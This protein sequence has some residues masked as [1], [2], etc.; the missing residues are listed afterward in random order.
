MNEKAKVTG[1]E[2]TSELNKN[3]SQLK[4][5]NEELLRRTTELSKVNEIALGIESVKSIE[6]VYKLVVESAV[7]I[8]GV[9][10]VI[11]HQLDE[12]GE[13]ITT[14]YFSKIRTQKINT[15]LKAMGFDLEKQLGKKPTSRKLQIPIAKLKIAKD[16]MNNRRIIVKERMS[17]LLDGY[18]SKRLCDTIQKIAG[19]KRCVLIPLITNTEPNSII[20]FYLDDDVP[21]YVL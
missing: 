13:Y 16:Y 8:P 6:D 10:F 15:T 7:D 14:P 12:S 5:T 4:Q 20:I 18:W 2:T 17:E 21:Q 19:F 1:S 11:V 9:K 3:I